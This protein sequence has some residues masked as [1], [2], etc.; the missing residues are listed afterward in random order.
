VSTADL[1]HILNHNPNGTIVEQDTNGPYSPLPEVLD[2]NGNHPDMLLL[3]YPE[4][5]N[6]SDFSALKT[7]VGNQ[8]DMTLYGQIGLHVYDT[9]ATINDFM[10]S[11]TLKLSG[12]GDTVNVGPVSGL[13]PYLETIIA[14]GGSN[15]FNITDGEITLKL[16]SSGHNIINDTAP[17]SEPN[18]LNITGMTSTDI[19]HLSESQITNIQTTFNATGGKITELTLSA[20]SQTETVTMNGWH[21]AVTIGT[22]P[23]IHYI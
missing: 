14:K 21:E 13:G 9:N 23:T 16:G 4:T 15:T 2:A 11:N 17:Y 12:A 5:I 8:S 19:L 6:T 10:Y 18:I 1:T 7:I 3:S 22:D 20:E